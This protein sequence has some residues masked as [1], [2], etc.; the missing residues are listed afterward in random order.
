MERDP[1]AIIQAAKEA[2]LD[3]DAPVMVIEERE[4]I[5]TYVLSLY[6]G[7]RLEWPPAQDVVAEGD[8]SPPAKPSARRSAKSAS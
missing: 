6:N 1:A 4:E 5:G 3:I 8:V 7:K 2:G